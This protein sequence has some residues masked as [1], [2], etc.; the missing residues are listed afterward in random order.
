[1]VVL[2]KII[3]A[4]PIIFSFLA[5]WRIE[6]K[7]K[8]VFTPFMFLIYWQFVRILPAFFV[9]DHYG[10]ASDLQPLM[11]A[12]AA[13]I[14]MIAGFVCAYFAKP[15]SPNYVLKFNILNTENYSVKSDRFNTGAVLLLSFFLILLGLW[16]YQGLPATISSVLGLFGSAGD[17]LARLVTQ[18]RLELTKG[19]Y[20]GGA[21]RGQGLIRSIMEFGWTFVCCYMAVFAAKSRTKKVWILFFLTIFLTW[22]FV[23]GD[24]TRGPFLYLLIV[25]L[26]ANS[27]YKSLS[28]RF[29]MIVALMIFFFGIFLSLYSAKMYN[30][31]ADPS[32]SFWM[33]SITK[34]TNRIFLGN[35][36]NDVQIIELV[37][38]G[39]WDV[40]FGLAHI[41]N[42]ITSIPGVTYGK[43][44]SYELFTYLNPESHRATFSSGTY[45]SVIYVDFSWYGVVFIYYM[46][47]IFVGI[48]QKL[49][50][51]SKPS[52]FAISIA[53]VISSYST[54]VMS[55]GFS[56]VISN[57][58]VGIF[59]LLIF[60]FF[61]KILKISLRKQNIM[62]SNF[63]KTC[64]TI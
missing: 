47:G 50:F 31:L 19:A 17:D 22:L 51:T 2:I 53:A 24:G 64:Q 6:S 11:V 18:Q 33:E 15:V 57:F 56:G 60:L 59:L 36:L 43:P 63:C 30:I 48:V 7:W 1:M 28:L 54:R 35:A 8:I 12:V 27:M 3:L 25:V 16:F 62:S 37:N 61:R 34:I 58:V 44:I 55:S 21:Y 46:V 45:L 38:S 32:R 4:I 20:F 29:V 23:A 5:V 42:F 41:R 13:Y 14:S 10:M 52:L 26:A 40:R 39:E 9:A 49:I